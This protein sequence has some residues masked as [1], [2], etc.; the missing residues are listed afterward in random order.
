MHLENAH[1]RPA[2]FPVDVTSHW[3]YIRIDSRCHDGP[4]LHVIATEI[5]VLGMSTNQAVQTLWWESPSESPAPAAA[6]ARP[7]VSEST[8]A[9]SADAVRSST[10]S[11]DP[12]FD[13]DVLLRLGPP[14]RSVYAQAEMGADGRSTGRVLMQDSLDACA[15][16]VSPVIHNLL[17]AGGAGFCK[18][19][20]DHPLFAEVARWAE[21]HVPALDRN[22]MHFT[23]GGREER[24]TRIFLQHNL[25]VGSRAVGSASN[26]ALD[27][28][29]GRAAEAREPAVVQAVAAAAASAFADSKA[30]FA[31]EEDVAEV[32]RRC[33]ITQEGVT[34]P[35]QL[36]RGLYERVNKVLSAAGGR[37]NRS[38]GAH[39]FTRDPREVLASVL[40]TGKAVNIQKHFQAF[41]TPDSVADLLCSR[42]NLAEYCAPRVLEPSCGDGQ[43]LRAIGRH[44]TSAARIQAYEIDAVAAHAARAAANANVTIAEQDFLT[45]P[46]RG[47]FDV[48]VMNPP[49]TRGADIAHVTHALG[50]LAKHGRLTSIMSPSWQT[51]GN[52]KAKAFRSLMTERQA[53]VES[54]PAGAFHDS[55][56]EVATVLVT[57]RA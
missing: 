53:A 54:L 23:T 46:A 20:S 9:N 10:V 19:R 51:A 40:E 7:M 47:E 4:G 12:A 11:A 33:T 3:E 24:R 57:V 30:T 38:R 56:T 15:T 34:L 2:H 39:L 32:L 1:I 52:A 28:A 13:F 22:T 5:T 31:V 42:A 14:E 50:H 8:K 45:V 21:R 48:V 25:I 27:R 44:S 18:L 26:Q 55:G 37:W 43:L 41:Y 16:G 36:S 29:L 49:F 35:G 6:A 17:A